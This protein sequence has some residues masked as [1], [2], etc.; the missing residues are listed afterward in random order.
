M[1]GPNRIEV[2]C[3]ACGWAASLLAT[4]R[5]S[6]G[7]DVSLVADQPIKIH[8]CEAG[9]IVLITKM[10]AQVPPQNHLVAAHVEWFEC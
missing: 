8:E 2:G 4:L 3:P 9:P 1:S 7:H 5:P 10:H 6:Y